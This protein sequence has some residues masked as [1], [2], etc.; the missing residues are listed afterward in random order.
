VLLV[1]VPGSAKTL[2]IQTIAPALD[3]EFSHIQFTPDL[4][5]SDITGTEL[6]EEDHGTGTRPFIFSKDP[7]FSK[8]VMAD[9][10]SLTEGPGRAAAGDAGEDRDRGG[11]D[12]CPA[13]P[14]L[15][16]RD[17]EPD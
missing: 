15:G 8:I 5:A 4:M 10:P 16:A 2:L 13:R 7:V 6:L 14:A 17:A 11:Q 9:Q 12:V 3:M 1:G